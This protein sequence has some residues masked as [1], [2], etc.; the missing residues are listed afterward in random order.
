MIF[1]DHDIRDDWNTSWS[2]RQDM[3]ATTW[4]HDRVVG[5]L[6]SYWIYQHLG[7]LGPDERAEDELWQRVAS[8]DGAEELDLTTELDDLADRADRDPDCYRWSYAREF[9]TQARLVVVDSRAARVLRPDRRSML[10]D[11]ERAWVDN[12]MRGDVDHLLVGTSLPF[13]MAPALHHIES[14]SEAIAQGAWGRIG[15]KLGE[16][17]RVTA[18][19]EHWA[20][21]QNGFRDMAADGAGGRLG[22]TRPPTADDHLPLRRRPSQLRRR[23]LAAQRLVTSRI[24]Q[25]VCSPIRN[26]LPGVMKGFTAASARRATGLAFRVLSRSG[27]VPLEPIRWVGHQGSVVPQQPRRPRD[28]ARRTAHVVDD[29]RGRRRSAR[30][31]GDPS[32]R[33]GRRARLTRPAD[34]VRKVANV[35]FRPV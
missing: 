14:F 26:P 20:A 4:W 32:G 11:S 17:A 12:L 22:Q 15:K 34:D 6:A 16:K 9:D 1:D 31:P 24:L 19:L 2:W 5:G 33:G 35:R 25:A 7:N 29:R 3:E 8:Y 18:D 10:D 30:P 28:R 27:R 21:F 13:L 23:G